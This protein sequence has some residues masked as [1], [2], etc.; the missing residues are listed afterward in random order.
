[1][2]HTHMY[3]CALA[4]LPL[5]AAAT[6]LLLAQAALRPLLAPPARPPSPTRHLH[7]RRSLRRCWKPFARPRRHPLPPPPP[8]LAGCPRRRRGLVHDGRHST[9]PGLLLACGSRPGM[10][11]K[12]QQQKGLGPPLAGLL[13]APLA[14]LSGPLGRWRW[15]AVDV[16]SSR[17]AGRRA[18]R[19]RFMRLLQRGCSIRRR[20]GAASTSREALAALAAR[21]RLLLVLPLLVVP[22]LLP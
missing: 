20:G 10:L 21:R 4:S 15:A 19:P 6:A 2:P 18:Y 14:G 3:R 9:S 16:R 7:P 5:T 11:P 8:P 17:P 13:A 12:D 1:M 22:V